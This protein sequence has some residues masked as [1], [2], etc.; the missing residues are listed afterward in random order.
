MTAALVLLLVSVGV[1]AYVYFGYPLLLKL[2]VA[3]RGRRVVRQRPIEPSVSLLISAYNEA[4]VIGR[5]LENALRLDYPPDRLEIIVVSDGSTDGT[6][7]IVRSFAARGVR[8]FRQEPRQGKTAG[9]NRAVPAATGEIIVFSDANAIYDAAA[10]RMLVRNFADPGV[11]CVT[12]EARYLASGRAASDLGERVYWDYEMQIKRLETAL[13]SMVGGDGAIYAI[14]RELWTPLPA[15]AINDF[16]NP[17]QIVARGWRTVYEPDAFCWEETAGRMRAEYRRR[18]RIVSRSWRAVFQAGDV[19]NPFKVGIFAW[20]VVSHKVLRWFTGVFLMTGSAAGA[21]L[22]IGAREH[23]PVPL[24]LSL[25]VVV[26]GLLLLRAPRRA[27]SMLT[28]FALI[29]AASTIGLIKGTFGDVSGIW[30]TPRQGE[31]AAPTPAAPVRVGLL[32]LLTLPIAAIVTASTF[33]SSHHDTERVFWVSVAALGYIFFGYPMVLL[34]LKILA[35][36]PVLSQPIE[37]RVCLLVAA[38]DEAAVIGAKLQN[39]LSLDYPADRLDIVVVSDG[40][41]DGTDEIVRGFAPRV[42]L[43]ALRPRRGKIAAINEGMESVHS[44]IVVFS[45][46][47]TFLERDAIRAIVKNFADAHVGAVSGDVALIGER[48]ALG[49]SEDLYYRYER[50]IQHAESEVGSMIGVDGALYAIRRELFEPQPGD[51]ILDDMAIPMAVIRRGYRVVFEPAARAHEQGSSSA[52]EEFSR[53]AR[54]V[55]GA[56]QFL[57]RRQSA[58]PLNRPQVMLSLLS[59]KGLRWMTPAFATMALLASVSLASSSGS[60]AT[61]AFAQIVLLSFGLAGCSPTLRKVSVVG[62]AHYFCLVQA[63]AAV[64][65]FRGLVGRQSVLWRRFTRGPLD[66]VSRA[67]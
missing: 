56:V 28:Y 46:A 16:L 1:V 63:A 65:F 66:E 49:S 32:F 59:H 30:S 14:R 6:D 60:Y 29:N 17:L 18:I 20:S 43:L 35:R 53:K 42:R 40:S 24:I 57:R 39:A 13:G 27:A 67:A 33:G 23:I 52:K 44:E 12:G 25:G 3:T 41:L 34:L 11:G 48:A 4:A 58:V 51:T 38:N 36:R 10:I 9:L 2:V 31:A 45:D 5:K 47:N 21:A 19:L 22:V 61:A 26:G 15:N 55:A 7:D 8:L 62:L 50:W 37:P 64:G 54:V